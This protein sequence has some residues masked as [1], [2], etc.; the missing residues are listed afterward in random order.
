MKKSIVLGIDIGGSGVKG[1]LVDTSKGEFVSER[2]RIPTPTPHTLKT[3]MEAIDEIVKQFKWNGVIGCGFPGV[4]RAQ[5]IETAANLGGKNF[6]G[7]NLAEEIGRASGCDTWIVNDADAAGIAEQKFGAGK[8]KQGVIMMFTVGTGIGVSM[9]TSGVLVPNLE[10][11]HLKMRDKASKKNLSAEKICSDAVRKSHDLQWKQ[12][13]QRFNKYLEYVHSLCW[14]DLM[15]LGGGV[16]SKSDKFIKYIKVDCDLVI[17][18]LENRAGII[19]AA[20]E[21]KRMVK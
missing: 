9:F 13:A 11:G 18:K 10:F 1:A 14:P 3:L 16:A 4:V 20:C 6:V 5:I 2:I 8:G 21:A 17:A 15:I 7:V 19:G 12:W